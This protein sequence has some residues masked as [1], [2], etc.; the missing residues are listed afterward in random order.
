[1]NHLSITE[2]HFL[3]SRQPI[4]IKELSYILFVYLLVYV[5]CP[6]DRIPFEFS[7]S[8]CMRLLGWQLIINV[9]YFFYLLRDNLNS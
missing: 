4:R 3:G 5:Y 8:L 6:C 9:A 7:S 2:H 1:M